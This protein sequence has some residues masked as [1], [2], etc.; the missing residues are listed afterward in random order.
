MSTLSYFFNSSVTQFPNNVLLR[1]KQGDVWTTLTYS[2]VK[3]QVDAL[4]A[5]FIQLGI[6]HGDRVALISEGRNY[7]LVTELALVSIGAVN[8]PLSVKL[9]EQSEIRFRIQH[10]ES[11]M[12]ITSATQSAKIREL[13]NEL[14]QTEWI[15]YFDEQTQ[16]LDNE[17]FIGNLIQKGREWLQS[18]RDEFEARCIA[19]TENDAANICYT[20]G[21][22]S[23]PKGIILSHRNY[24][25]NVEQ[26][27]TLMDIPEYYCNLLILPWDHSFAHTA[28]LY[29]F[30]GKGASIASVQ[31]G[32]TSMETLKNIPLNIKEVKPHLLMS[33]PALARNFKKNIEK[34]I[35]DQGMVAELL[36]KIALRTAYIYNKEGNNKGSGLAFLLKPLVSLFDKILFCKIRLGFGGNLIFFIGGGALLD[37]DLQRFFYAIGIPMMQGY[38]LSEA[39]PIIS[40]N[41]LHRHKLGSSGYLVKPMEF[42]ICDF[43]GNKITSTEQGEI[44][45]RGGN[46]M[47]GYWKNEKATS[48]TIKDGWLYTGDMGNLDKDGFLYVQGRFKSL[49][50]GNDGEKFSPEG[51]E[52]MMEEHISFVDQVMLY[53]NQNP[54]TTALIVP[55]KEAIRRW[56]K[57]HHADLKQESGQKNFLKH[58]QHEINQYS[59]GGKHAGHFPDRWLPVTFALLE[60]P[61]TEQN[62]FLNSTMKMVRG[63]ITDYYKE[64]L[65]FLY[66]PEGKDIYNQHNKNIIGKL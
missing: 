51:I 28:G 19:V 50:I 27:Y 53:N 16:Y 58:L 24:T 12:V 45:I 57:H 30:I 54:Y 13:R 8:V 26:A 17:L 4:A 46:V 20:S 6:N 62:R 36:F 25:A 66:T 33:V 38:G 60:E 1:E 40:S 9:L 15:L 2:E 29:S 22:T 56:A 41:S 11:R 52:G 42:K 55:N 32:K 5:G 3:E 64:L 35:H 34:G 31:V 61:F 21:T 14:T 10:S 43:D 49:L 18:H 48:E 65:N 59:K 63:R 23:D 39:S 47:K 37:I 44:V 7:W